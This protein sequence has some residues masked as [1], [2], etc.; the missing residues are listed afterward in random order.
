MKDFVLVVPSIRENSW[1]R[2]VE[3][4]DRIDLFQLVDVILME[5][6]PTKTFKAD[7]KFTHLSWEDID[8]DL[9]NDSWIIPRRSDTVRSYGYYRAW[10][11]GNPYIVT[12]DD[13]CYPPTQEHDGF[14][15]KEGAQSFLDLHKDPFVSQKWFNTLNNVKPRGIPFYNKGCDINT[16]VNHG[17]W[18]NV[19][20]Y[21]APTQLVNPIPEKFAYDSRIVPHG[22]FFP[23][24]GMNV[25]W[26]REVTVWM[27]HLLMGRQV[28]REPN[29]LNEDGTITTFQ[30]PFDRFGDIWAGIFMKKLADINGFNVA[31]GLPYI[32]HDRASNAFANLKK[33]ANGLE[34]NEKLWE[35]VDGFETKR[36]DINE[37]Y[38]ELGYYISSYSEF[39]QYRKYFSELGEA[40]K[41]WSRL[42]MRHK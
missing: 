39:Q 28:D 12:L 22:K 16:I 37:Q 8:A 35:F 31:T 27:Y 42:F 25:A 5:D 20:D 34:V 6:N 1:N 11:A 33:E 30:L 36:D 15:Y 13:D 29:V 2:F 40:M 21:D 32:H 4:W 18:T 17:L 14:H 38:E 7:S 26:K 3:E 24:C 41:I 9:N 19:L 10:Q 23:M